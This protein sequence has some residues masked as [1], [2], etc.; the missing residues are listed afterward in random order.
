MTPLRPGRRSARPRPALSRRSRLGL[1]A[2]NFCLADIGGGLGPYL[3]TWLA[4][5]AGWDPLAIGSLRL[6]TNV[7]TLAVSTPAGMLVDRVG[8]HRR[9]LACA[10]LCVLAGSLSL[11]WFRCFWPVLATQVAVALGS[12]LSMPALMALTPG[13]VGKHGFARQFGWNQAADHVGNMAAAS[14][15]AVLSSSIGDIAPF[16]VLGAL[17][18]GT[19]LSV[20]SIP[21]SAIDQDRAR[22]HGA[23]ASHDQRG[24]PPGSVPALLKDR[25]LLNLLAVI[26]LFNLGNDQLLPLL[27]Q[28]L[29]IE[30]KGDPTTWMAVWILAA[31]LTMIPMA[32][33]GGHV[34]GRHGALKIMLASCVVLALRAVLAAATSGAQWGLAVEVMDGIGAGMISV[35][36][37]IA[38][39]DLTYGGGRTQTAIGSLTALGGIA[40]AV[41]AIAGGAVASWAGWPAALA[42]MAL[43]PI[44]AVL[45]LSRMLR[46]EA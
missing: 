7:V 35:A 5:A 37:P 33:I 27:G 14:V 25:R 12:A 9:M 43:P 3:A 16:V 13:V 17:S 1:V 6:A 42:M 45:L 29:A 41:S 10:C 28:R 4:G 26:T 11:L 31:Q 39:T 15:I 32:M 44:A 2:T 24:P 20:F 36:G 34:A 38:V 21:R 46:R 30:G 18:V 40:A 8:R 23:A 19:I 22:G